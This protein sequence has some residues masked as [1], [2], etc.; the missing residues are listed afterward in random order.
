MGKEP[1]VTNRESKSEA[2]SW[3]GKE[4]HSEKEGKKKRPLNFGSFPIDMEW[5][6]RPSEEL[7]FDQSHHQRN[8]KKD[9]QVLPGER[10]FSTD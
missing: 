6:A 2:R 3:K 10:L 8:D 9:S 5:R 1:E 7:S 4:C